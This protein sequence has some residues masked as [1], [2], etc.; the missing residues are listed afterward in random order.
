MLKTE[1][2]FEFSAVVDGALKPKAFF[3]S[4]FPVLVFSFV[5]ALSALPSLHCRFVL[6]LY[7][8][9]FCMSVMP[10]LG[11]SFSVSQSIS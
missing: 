10:A 2:R 11:F 7:C 3:P 6:F 4:Y 9:L 8:R 1:E 5:F